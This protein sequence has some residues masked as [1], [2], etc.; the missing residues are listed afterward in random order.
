MI[1]HFFLNKLLNSF[2]LLSPHGDLPAE[3]LAL[4]LLSQDNIT[5]LKHLIGVIAV[6]LLPS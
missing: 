3:H 6:D 2:Y 1:L 5:H 4:L